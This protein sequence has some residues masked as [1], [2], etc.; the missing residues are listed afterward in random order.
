[1]ASPSGGVQRERLRAMRDTMVHRG[2]DD[3]GEY[4]TA[5]ATLG[6]AHRRLAIIDL[7]EA[8]HQPM[9][10]GRGE[11]WIVF[12]GEIYNYKSLREELEQLGHR[13]RS[14]SDTEVILEAYRA[15][16]ERC[17]SRLNGMFAFALF[18]SRTRQLLL[19][20][21]RAG[22]KP[23]FY[24]HADGQLLFA[25]ELKALMAN[26][27]VPREVDRDALTE[28]L[29]YGYVWGDRCMLRGIRKLPPAH[30]MTYRLGSGEAR[31]WR[32]WQLPQ[33]VA[34]AGRAEELADELEQL[35][36]DSVRRQLVADVPVSILLS[37]G[38]DSSLIT[39]LAARCSTKPVRTFN[40]SFPGH[41]EFDEAPQARLVAG[42]FGTEHVELTAEPGTVDLLPQLARQYD[43]PLGDPSMVPTY[44][45]S[46]LISQRAKV[47]LGGD[48]GDELFGGY[49]H[50]SWIPVQQRVR[51]VVPGAIRALGATAAAHLLPVGFPARNQMLGLRRDMSHHIAQVRVYFDAVSRRRLLAP[52]W[53]SGTAEEITPEERKASLCDPAQT[54]L[55]RAVRNDF[56][57]YMVDDV[58]VKVDRAS[59]LASLEVRA[60]MLDYRVIEFAIGR[61]PDELKA[62]RHARKVLLRHL[63]RRLLPRGYDV[64]RKRGFSVPDQWFS[65][66]WGGFMQEVLVQAD[67]RLFDQR[68]IQQLVKAQQ[69]GRRHSERLFALTMFELWR[70][71][72]GV[73][74]PI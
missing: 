28:Y 39:A 22:E 70:R 59:M 24:R 4:W 29:T 16:G 10:D 6:L 63:A 65:G 15:W 36:A 41:S 14:T 21:D 46:R 30:A 53:R 20:R 18:D 42:H 5:D 37:G 64:S 57:T 56:S 44:L 23:L 52:A 66:A 60:P 74:L 9:A 7:S 71:A 51:R 8:G 27:E 19:A 54:P 61:V 73:A 2:P 1:M 43:E 62:S 17:L 13:F 48:G 47:A 45:V 31:V 40:V 49:L 12:N 69:R 68:F 35:L 34:S 32:Y 72:Y 26:P 38:L 3:A 33:A 25:S 11:L 55:Q 58:L 50:Y 67:A